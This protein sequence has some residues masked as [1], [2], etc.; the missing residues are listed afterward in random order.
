MGV[1]SWKAG[2]RRFLFGDD[3]ALPACILYVA[4]VVLSPELSI[5][6]STWDLPLRIGLASLVLI[7]PTTSVAL[8]FSSMTTESRYA[9]FGWFAIWILGI[10]SYSVVMAFTVV[11]FDGPF[12]DSNLG[13]GWQTLLSPYHTLGVVQSYVF[14]MQA[15]NSPVV[16]AIL[17][18]VLVTIGSLAV[19]YRR[20]SLPMRA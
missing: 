19:V 2:N 3:H 4:G 9:G 14:D 7:V 16:A 17:M 15:E 1:H 11:S 10:V 5:V 8:M 18:L 6:F 13:T 20:V 12:D